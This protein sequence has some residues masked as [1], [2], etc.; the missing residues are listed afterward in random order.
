MKQYRVHKLSA[1]TT[2]PN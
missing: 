1:C 2:L